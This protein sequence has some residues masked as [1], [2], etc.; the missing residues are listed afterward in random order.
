ML[1][2]ES[3]LS[4]KKSDLQ[5]E[6]KREKCKDRI[7]DQPLFPRLFQMKQHIIDTKIIDCN[8][9]QKSSLQ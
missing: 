5:K 7:Q 6:K 3:G 1:H 2:S 4:L 9:K 8:V